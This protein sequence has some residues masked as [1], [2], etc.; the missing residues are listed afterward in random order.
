METFFFFFGLIV[1]VEKST[2]FETSVCNVARFA[3]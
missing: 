1:G 2:L 3:P